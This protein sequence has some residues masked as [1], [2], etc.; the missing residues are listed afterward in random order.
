MRLSIE[1][2]SVKVYP[3]MER[4]IARYFFTVRSVTGKLLVA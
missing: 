1:R 4:V 3:D 2:E